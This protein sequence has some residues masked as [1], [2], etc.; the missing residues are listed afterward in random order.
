MRKK[1]ISVREDYTQQ[2][3]RMTHRIDVRLPDKIYKDL[4]K[5]PDGIT[6][7][8]REALTQYLYNST[9]DTYNQDP[10]Y[11]KH[12]ENEIMFLRTQNDKLMIAG[13]PLLSKIKMYLLNKDNK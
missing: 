6:Y 7:N 10:T 13:L 12:L 11:I 8:V 5:Q 4:K 2:V 9:Q 1:L 3:D